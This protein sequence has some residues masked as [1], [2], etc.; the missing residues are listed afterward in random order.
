MRQRH[1]PVILI[2][3]AM[4]SRLVVA[5]RPEIRAWIPYRPLRVLA[6]LDALKCDENGES[7][8]MLETDGCLD[9][10]PLDFVSPLRRKLGRHGLSIVTFPYDWRMSLFQS[11]ES[12]AAWVDEQTWD[13]FD[14]VGVSSGGLIATQYARMG[15]AHRIRK[16]I[17]IGTPFLGMPRALAYLHTGAVLNRIADFFF[18]HKAGALIR[19]F[20][21]MYE[22]LPCQAFFDA[23][24][25]ACAE[26]HGRTLRSHAQM[27]SWLDSLPQIS[28]RLL[29]T[30]AEFLAQLDPAQTLGNVDTSYIV[31]SGRPTAALVSYRENGTIRIRRRTDG[32]GSVPLFSQTIGGRN[33]AVHPGQ[34]YRFGGRHRTT[35]MNCRVMEQ[36]VRILL[37]STAR[38]RASAG[39]ATRPSDAGGC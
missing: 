27:V 23:A 17:S 6:D 11:A 18:A 22:L 38:C 7:C 33:E 3:G 8:M 12:F 13:R 30:G 28:S 39:P 5:G 34:T 1:F 9:A 21:S 24:N 36:I 14:I 4:G 26:V 35:H 25:N 10:R 29:M 31:N 32:D 16:F 19:T 20:P 37:D 15:F 2:L